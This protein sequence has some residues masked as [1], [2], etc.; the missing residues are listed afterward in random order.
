QMVISGMLKKLGCQV[1]VAT[2]GKDA[3]ASLERE[4]FDLVLMDCDMP[5]LDGLAAT[6][7]IRAEEQ[8]SNSSRHLPVVAVTSYDSSEDQARC[9]A[10]GMD[11]YVVKPLRY[12]ELQGR[13]E[14]WLGLG[15]GRG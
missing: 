12:E 6:E 1:H 14:H 9:R 4:K 10:A 8:A 7:K 2:D 15:R 13:L 5:E 11:D 3:L